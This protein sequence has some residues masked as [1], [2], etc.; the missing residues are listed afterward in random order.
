MENTQIIN[1]SVDMNRDRA[2]VDVTSE[3]K[4]RFF[5]CILSD[6]PY[7]ELISLF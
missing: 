6:K 1:P 7:E 3:D 4:E 2:K 5:K